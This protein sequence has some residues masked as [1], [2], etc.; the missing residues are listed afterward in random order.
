M[1]SIECLEERNHLIK[2]V[3]I[4][5]MEAHLPRGFANIAESRGSQPRG[6]RSSSV[7]VA[8]GGIRN[9]ALSEKGLIKVNG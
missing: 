7:V 3:V 5:S 1:R 9:R 8:V 2:I 4:H 6:G